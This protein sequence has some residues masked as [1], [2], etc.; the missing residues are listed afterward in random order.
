[1]SYA[2]SLSGNMLSAARRAFAAISDASSSVRSGSWL[3][4]DITMLI[5]ICRRRSLFASSTCSLYS[6][7]GCSARSTS[8][9]PPSSSYLYSGFGCWPHSP[10]CS[11]RR[12]QSPLWHLSPANQAALGHTLCDRQDDAIV[13]QGLLESVGIDSDLKSIDAV[14]D[15]F[16]GVGGTVILVREEDAPEAGKIIEAY[17]HL[18]PL[19]DDETADIDI[20]GV[21]GESA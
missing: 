12:L 21:R 10:C 19:D 17:R 4:T 1:M 7:P 6:P 18:P 2:S 3:I 13:V 15:A 5:M 16:P 20:S 9:L 8:I 11:N 14:Q